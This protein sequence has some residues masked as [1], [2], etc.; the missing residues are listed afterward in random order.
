VPCNLLRRL[1][2]VHGVHCESATILALRAAI[3]LLR[4]GFS[5]REFF[6][7]VLALFV[8]ATHVVFFSHIQ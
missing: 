4:V 7:D 6:F 2:F 5:L 1:Q 3:I 8:R